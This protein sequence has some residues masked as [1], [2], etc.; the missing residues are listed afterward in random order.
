MESSCRL[1]HHGLTA[2]GL[3]GGGSEHEHTV[4]A[5]SGMCAGWGSDGPGRLPATSDGLHRG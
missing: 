2:A 3:L 4:R 1:T 5:I